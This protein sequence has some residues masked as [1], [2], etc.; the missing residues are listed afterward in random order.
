[1]YTIKYALCILALTCSCLYIYTHARFLWSDGTFFPCIRNI[2]TAMVRY[3]SLPLPSSSVTSWTAFFTQSAKHYKL[4]SIHGVEC[5]VTLH[6]LCH[7]RTFATPRPVH[8]G[9]KRHLDASPAGS[10]EQRVTRP[11]YDGGHLPQQVSV[12]TRK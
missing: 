11:Q 2:I 8:A 12:T 6:S 5:T 9:Y 10:L 7:V 4:H 3:F 1:M